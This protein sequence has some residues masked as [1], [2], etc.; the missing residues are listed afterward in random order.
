MKWYYVC[1][2]AYIH[3]APGLEFADIDPSL[4]Y[5][6]YSQLVWENGWYSRRKSRE[7]SHY[8]WSGVENWGHWEDLLQR[9]ISIFAS[10]SYQ[11]GKIGEY[12]QSAFHLPSRWA[13]AYYKG[14]MDHWRVTWKECGE[15]ERMRRKQVFQH[16][17]S[18]KEEQVGP[19]ACECTQA[20]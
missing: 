10:S 19:C 4:F 5:H 8:I 16:V 17:K 13:S 3:P 14:N 15:E 18:S 9:W 2:F 7:Q 12:P 20:F 6:L 1:L 11:G